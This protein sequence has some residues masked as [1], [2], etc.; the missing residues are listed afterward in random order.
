MRGG[1]ESL[2]YGQ[3]HTNYFK[4]LNNEF[5]KYSFESL[6]SQGTSRSNRNC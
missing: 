6:L 4:I 1:N 5:N 3:V 2:R